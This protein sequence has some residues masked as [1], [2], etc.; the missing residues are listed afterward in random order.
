MHLGEPLANDIADVHRRPILTRSETTDGELLRD[1]GEGPEV[2][3]EGEQDFSSAFL[4][5]G[6]GMFVKTFE[7]WRKAAARKYLSESVSDY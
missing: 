6:A 1:F 5:V 4:P 7:T 2:D 3:S